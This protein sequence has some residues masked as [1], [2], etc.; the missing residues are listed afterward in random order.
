MKTL[1]PDQ[2]L[3]PAPVSQHSRFVTF[4][5]LRNWRQRAY[6]ARDA[7]LNFTG[8]EGGVATPSVID[9]MDPD[10]E[11]TRCKIKDLNPVCY[12]AIYL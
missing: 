9:G 10:S 7:L 3:A 6:R 8:R 11:Q 1:E 2:K 4:T 5:L 12:L